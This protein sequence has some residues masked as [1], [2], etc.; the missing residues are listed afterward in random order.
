MSR[1]LG[2]L[3]CEVHDHLGLSA[4]P[5]IDVERDDFVL[6]NLCWTGNWGAPTATG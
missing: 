5:D 6:A 1:L 4:L 2:A 3:C